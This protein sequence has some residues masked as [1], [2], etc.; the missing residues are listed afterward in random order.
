MIELFSKININIQL[1]K[2]YSWSTFWL[3]HFNMT[4]AQS[5]GAVE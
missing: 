5:A 3:E 2:F 4:N 1:S